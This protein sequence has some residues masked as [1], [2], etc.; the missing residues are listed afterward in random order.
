M[1]WREQYAHATH[2]ARLPTI[3]LSQIPRDCGPPTDSAEQALEVVYTM[4]AGRSLTDLAAEIERQASSKRDFLAATQALTMQV[5]QEAQQDFQRLMSQPVGRRE[6][7]SAPTLAQSPVRI[8]IP[9]NGDGPMTFGVRNLAHQQIAQK[10]AIPQKYYE[11]MAVE[12]PDLLAS[13]VNHWLRANPGRQMLRTLDG[14]LRAYLSDSYRV[15]DYFDYLEAILPVIQQSGLRIESCEVTESRLYLKCVNERITGEVVG[16]VVQAGA[17]FSTSEVGH[18][19]LNIQQMTYV[20]RCTNGMIGESMLRRIHLGRKQGGG[21]GEADAWEMFSD[22][23]RKLSDA[24]LWNQVRDV[25]TKV[26]NDQSWFDGVLNKARA[27]AGEKITGDPVGALVE[28]QRET[29]M[30]EHTRGGVLRHLIEGGDLSKWGVVQAITRTAQDAATYEDATGM[31]A[32]GGKVLELPK[33][34]WE[35]IAQAAPV[36][37]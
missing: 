22:A 1:R 4:K 17:V 32:L 6:T 7:H 14:D 35:R 26:L 36:A 20:L 25:S 19:A 16:D 27:A 12:A 8:Q 11:R 21:D 24:A 37:V 30:S 34:S 13:N 9:A 3:V 33:A 23:T 28:L 10:L 31:E 2:A 29:R 15:M 18:G 5:D